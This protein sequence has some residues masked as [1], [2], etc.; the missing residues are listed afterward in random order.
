MLSSDSDQLSLAL[1]SPMI[2]RTYP[3][4][5]DWFNDDLPSWFDVLEY[6]FDISEIIKYILIKSYQIKANQ[7]LSVDRISIYKLFSLILLRMEL[8]LRVIDVLLF[9]GYN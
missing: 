1:V 4:R 5:E 7:H 6:D 8:N 9:S 2:S 3:F